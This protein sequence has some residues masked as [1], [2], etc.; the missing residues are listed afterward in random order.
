[1]SLGDTAPL[2]AIAHDWT[3]PIVRERHVPT[4]VIPARDG[5]EQRIGLSHIATDV[6]TYRL[7]PPTA[8]DAALLASVADVA[9]DR[10]VRV[11]RWEDLTRVDTGVSAGSAVVIPCDTT[12]RPTFASGIQVLLWRTGQQYEVVTASAVAS[13]SVTADLTSDWAAGTMVAPITAARIVLPLDVSV[14]GSVTS[15]ALELTVECTLADVAGVGTGGTASTGT[16]DALSIPDSAGIS[17]AGRS[18]LTATVTDAAGESIPASGIVWSSSDPS[19]CEVWATPDA[20]IA[21]IENRRTAFAT[22]DSATITATLGALSDTC[23]VSLG[24]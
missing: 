23:L 11:P 14:W 17:H 5:A 9:T 12:D 2:L 21:I 3:A 6:I 10:I 20:R 7:L 24:W 18:S 4:N 22:P 8:F 16:A 1:M 13:G 19:V 15:G